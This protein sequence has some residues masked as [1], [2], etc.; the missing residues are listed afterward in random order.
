MPGIADGPSMVVAALLVL[1]YTPIQIVVAIVVRRL[2]R[3]AKR[4]LEAADYL[5]LSIAVLWAIALLD[6]VLLLDGRPSRP[7]LAPGLALFIPKPA[8]ASQLLLGVAL[9]PAV[10]ASVRWGLDPLL[11]RWLGSWRQTPS[12][13][14]AFRLLTVYSSPAMA[15]LIL[16]TNVVEELLFRGVLVSQ[17]AAVTGHPLFS[18][19]FAGAVYGSYHYGLSPKDGLIHGLTGTVYGLLFVWGGLWPAIIAHILYNAC[20]IVQVRGVVRGVESKLPGPSPSRSRIPPVAR[21][22]HSVHSWPDGAGFQ[23]RL[24]SHAFGVLGDMRVKIVDVSRLTAL[25]RNGFLRRRRTR[26]WALLLYVGL[27]L[28]LFA[29]RNPYAFGMFRSDSEFVRAPFTSGVL[30]L[31]AGC[32]YLMPAFVA[33]LTHDWVARSALGYGLAD[34][35]AG[36]LSGGR[37]RLAVGRIQGVV[38][39]CMLG[40]AAAA[41]VLVASLAVRGHF[42]TVLGLMRLVWLGILVGLYV[43]G[44]S[45]LFA[46]VSAL[47]RSSEG[48]LIACMLTL[49]VIVIGLPLLSD[50]IFLY[51]QGPMPMP[52]TPEWLSY[53]DA[54]N[55]WGPGL[56][57]YLLSPTETFLTMTTRVLALPAITPDVQ[58]QTISGMTILPIAFMVFFHLAARIPRTTAVP[59]QLGR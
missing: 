48:A 19:T 29:L 49:A 32:Y 38:I 30:S 5:L 10:Y 11:Q 20:T 9:G 13:R 36:G 23:A 16:A 34:L 1:L 39:V 58:A 4:T 55:G 37:V 21:G 22:S 24:D 47:S 7:G 52:G 25:E 6:V 46:G 43:T 2:T 12:Q 17:V 31:I 26:Q 8:A 40:F 3:G 14:E 54:T 45:Y 50:Q 56:I 28:S 35:A 18:A 15:P 27:A 33:L 53:L 41:L 59:Q 44:L 51:T 42:P 57:P